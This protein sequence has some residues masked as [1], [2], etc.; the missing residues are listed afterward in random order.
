MAGI[1]SEALI[2]VEWLLLGIALVLILARLNLRINHLKAGF[3][4]GDVFILAAFAAAVSLNAVDI[5]LYHRGIYEADIDFKM[6]TWVATEEESTIVYRTLYY[7]YFP[8]YLEQYFNKGTLIALYY[9]V[10]GGG[11]RKIKVS[12]AALT[13]YCISGFITTICIILFLCEWGCYW[14]YDNPCPQRCWKVSD[15][16]GWAFHFSSDI[17]IFILPLVCISKLNM[18]KAQKISASITFCIGFINI[19]ITFA[20]WLVVQAVFTSVPALNTGQ[21]MAIADGHIG[22][23]VSILPSLR[24]YLRIWSKKRQD[25]KSSRSTT[26]SDYSTK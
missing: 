26:E 25:A 16:L 4:L 1:Q 14:S 2:A 7:L 13:F 21:A 24:P 5:T 9:E 19:S 12:L 18:T 20:R 11:S 3:V 8:F 17:F 10:F 6:T 23:I 15:N 22:L